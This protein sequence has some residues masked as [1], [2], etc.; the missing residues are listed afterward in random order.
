[1]EHFQ[2]SSLRRLDMTFSQP[3]LLWKLRTRRDVMDSRRTETVK[4]NA[5]E[6]GP[7]I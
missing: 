7:I 6:L 2:H 4:L 1:M 5:G 3:V